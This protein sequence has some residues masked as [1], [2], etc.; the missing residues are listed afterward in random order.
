MK[1]NL[2]SLLGGIALSVLAL[3]ATAQRYNGYTLY[4]TQNAT[5]AY[6]MDTNQ[7]T[8]HT[9]SGMSAQTG[10]SIH[11]EP[12]GTIVRAAKGG[13]N[14][15]GV[16]GGPICGKIQK[17]DYAGNLVWD[18]VYAGADYITHHDICPMP[19]GNVLVIAYERRTATEVTAAGGNNAIQMWPDKIVEI[20]PTGLTTGTVV[21]EWKTWDHICQ[22]VDPNKPNY[23]TSIVDNPQLININ[24]K[25]ASDW[26]HMNGVDY[27]PILDQIAFSSHNHN[28]WYIIDHSTTTAEAASHAGGNA[29]KGGDILYR[30]GNPVAYGA[31]GTAI[32]NVTHDAHW[33]AEGIP[34]AG[35]LAGFN[36]KGVSA[37]QSAA[38]QIDVPINGYNYNLTLGQAYAPA[39]YT[40]RHP[41]NGYSS[42][43]G[44]T[45][46]LPNG[47]QI[48]CVATSGKIY[49]IDPAGTQLWSKTVGGSCAQAKAYDSCFIFNAPP[50]IPTVTMAGSNL[51]SSSATTY[52]WYKDGVQI[53]GATSQTYTPTVSGIY[54]VRTTDANGCVY[55][56]S[57]GYKYVKPNSV[58]DLDLSS[59]YTVYPN[60]TSGLIQIKENNQ[61]VLVKA[62]SVFDLSGRLI[63]TTKNASEVNL[64]QF[65]T[66]V[67]SL[68][69]LTENGKIVK[70][71]N[72]IK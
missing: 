64:S 26:Q 13:T 54:I 55:R 1:M 42:N 46:Q 2:N 6:L 7:V 62:I 9:W 67:Y 22:N 61:Q 12:G 43:M 28:E 68:H 33:I 25:Q 31:A 16:P 69:I 32:L 66:G 38:D 72:L 45:Q 20:Q 40:Y 30:W 34:N 51:T 56:Y 49:E 71:V 10:Y 41:V 14:P 5:T 4:S 58:T 24:Y 70:Q 60:P 35:R 50:P 8:Y 59:A 39:S 63:L 47:N 44:S 19:N 23:V 27:N 3:S 18:Y 15:S 11:M 29:G 36:N 48:I 53:A 65:N 37:S 52:Q 17:H 21:W 57:A